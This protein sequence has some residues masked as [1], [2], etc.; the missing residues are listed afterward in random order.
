M[1]SV[2][3][4]PLPFRGTPPARQTAVLDHSSRY[5]PAVWQAA[6]PQPALCWSEV[7]NTLTVSIRSTPTRTL[8]LVSRADLFSLAA[9][10]GDVQGAL[11][12]F[13]SAAAW[14][15]GMSARYRE[16][17][18]KVLKN[19]ALNGQ[20]N[21]VGRKLADAV[22]LAR[23]ESPVAAYA[24]LHGTNRGEGALSIEY[25]G[26]AYGTKVLY[27]AAYS[28]HA[29]KVAPLILDRRVATALNWIR[30]TAWPMTGWT[31]D[32]Y[33]EYLHVAAAWAKQ[34]GTEAD[35]VERVLFAIGRSGDEDNGIA[36][37]SLLG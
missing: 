35:V 27:F 31:T 20:L 16:R 8:R 37:R 36:V 12:A 10:A 7:L 4:Q 15:V 29:G 26:P 9:R 32:Q 14:G 1:S 33:E 17:C 13:V 21:G 11:R 22:V 5:D 30:H 3:L 23:G 24:A 25:L 34:W 28:E 19:P 2:A 6:V 18:L